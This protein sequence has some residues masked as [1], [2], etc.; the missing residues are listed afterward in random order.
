MRL[1]PLRIAARLYIVLVCLY[2]MSPFGATFHGV[3][4][5]DSHHVTFG[6]IA[7]SLALWLVIR[8]RQKWRRPG[9][10][11]DSALPIWAVAIAISI[12]ANPGTMSRSFIGLWF[13][14]LY[15]GTWHVLRDLVSNRAEVRE[16]LIDAILSAGI[17]LVFFSVLQMVMSGRWMQPV[18]L[19]GNSNALG[20]I[21]LVIAPFAL[22]RMIAAR[23][24]TLKLGWTIYTFAVAA[25]VALT[26]S[27]GAWLSLLA[28][29]STLLILVLHDRGLLSIGRLRGRW[30][31]A[32]A[33]FRRLTIVGIAIVT[34]VIVILLGLIIN[35]FTIRERR[36]GLRGEIWRAALLQFAEKPLT[37]QGLFTFGRHYSRHVSVPPA[38]PYAHAHNLPL[39]VAAELGILGIVALICATVCIVG[40][41]R[42][43]WSHSASGDR[44]LLISCASAMVGFSAHHVFDFT[45]MMPA[46]AL[47]GIL[48]VVILPTDEVKFRSEKPSLQVFHPI[49]IVALWVVVLLFGWQSSEANRRYVHA[50]RLS[51]HGVAGR[52]AEEA[53]ADYR[54]SLRALEDLVT[55]DAGTPARLQQKA[56]LLGLLASYGDL[57]A[58][59]RAIATFELYLE[60][61]PYDAMSWANLAA[62]YWQS[63]NGANAM[64]ALERAIVLAPDS[65]VFA[66]NLATYLGMFT[67]EVLELPHSGHNQEFT[68]FQYLRESLPL[69]FLPQVGWGNR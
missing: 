54:N 66:Y 56:L 61:E 50:L 23:R 63:G 5:P 38:L 47:L 37:G 19:I 27:R 21:L 24:L 3:V 14:L 7:F 22:G 12:V 57:Q 40:D 18:S 52:T 13:V 33:S 10:S 65:Y 36:A 69:T 35:S 64:R 1:S 15:A 67:G 34:L 4:I 42:R 46:V 48:L 68:R 49:G 39:N 60:E 29:L 41:F 51:N 26:L 30:R 31:A 8:R 20:A 28:G 55:H 17:V 53:V 44:A 9:A 6:L 11:L 32:S 62:L 16:W 43:A 59:D 45:A 58:L 2:L 25:I